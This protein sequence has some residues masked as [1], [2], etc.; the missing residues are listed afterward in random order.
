MGTCIALCASLVGF[1]LISSAR[2]NL[3]NY[4]LFDKAGTVMLNKSGVATLSK[5]SSG[6]L[7]WTITSGTVDLVSKTHWQ[8]PDGNYS[9]DLVG[10]PGVG[11]IAQKVAT[12]TGTSYTLTFDLT[13][14]PEAGPRNEIGTT[15]VLLVQALAANGKTVLASKVF[16]VTPGSHTTQNMGWVS[17]NKFT[18]QATGAFSTIQLSALT[19]LNLPKGANSSNIYCGPVIDNLNLDLTA[20][21]SPTPVPEPT[22]LGILGVSASA[23]LLKR[24]RGR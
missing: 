16:D 22:S 10:T 18:F 9:V 12:T 17:D 19:P 5:N 2:A 4:G 23:L 7:G 13:A 21:G 15:K 1:V 14:N 24:R 11:A 6:L 3:L 20:G 8:T